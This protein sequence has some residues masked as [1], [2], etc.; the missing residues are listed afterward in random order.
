MIGWNYEI[1]NYVRQRNGVVRM[2]MEQVFLQDLLFKDFADEAINYGYPLPLMGDTRKKPDKDTRI[3]ALTF[4]FEKGNVIFNE[5]E[6]DNHHMKRLIDQFL[7]FQKG[8]RKIHK[9][10]PDAFEGAREKLLNIITQEPTPIV[11]Y[12]KPSG[13]H[14]IL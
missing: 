2:Y 8:A 11:G 9:D 1:Y 6:K 10:G 5:E 4:I 14:K 3:E 12:N 7:F 13:K